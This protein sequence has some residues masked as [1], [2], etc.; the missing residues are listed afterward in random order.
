MGLNIRQVLRLKT[1]WLGLVLLNSYSKLQE[2][3]AFSLKVLV[4]RQ[5]LNLH[6]LVLQTERASLKLHVE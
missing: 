4:K 5:Q 3:G 2:D 1:E 6:N